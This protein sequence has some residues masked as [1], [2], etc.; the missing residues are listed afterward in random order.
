MKKLTVTDL[1]YIYLKNRIGGTIH[2]Y[3]IQSI[4]PNLG[5]IYGI[6]HTPETYIRQWR[7]LKKKGNLKELKLKVL[8]PEETLCNI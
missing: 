7:T 5:K 8:N 6:T 2:N 3:E 4:L 1:L